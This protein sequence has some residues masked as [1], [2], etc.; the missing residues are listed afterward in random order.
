P[1]RAVAVVLGTPPSDDDRREAERLA[2]AG[3]LVP[4]QP[5]HSGAGAWDLGF[6]ALQA[7][8]ACAFWIFLDAFGLPLPAC[9]PPIALAPPPRPAVAMLSPWRRRSR[10]PR[11]VDAPLCPDP[12]HQLIR[13]DATPASAFRTAV[14][15]EQPFRPG[16]PREYDIWDLANRVMAKGWAAVAC[17]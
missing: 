14:L 5:D 12:R 7:R 13:N 6:S 9:L 16:L 8:G 11:P 17:P 1:P 2:A 3:T 15:D 4:F 10:G